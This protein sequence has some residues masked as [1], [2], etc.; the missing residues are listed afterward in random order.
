VQ[1]R[2]QSQARAQ[3][4]ALLRRA[5]LERLLRVVGLWVCPLPSEDPARVARQRALLLAPLPIRRSLAT[6]RFEPP[7]LAALRPFLRVQKPRHSQRA[8]APVPRGLMPSGW[9]EEVQALAD[10]ED[11]N[12]L[13]LRGYTGMTIRG[14]TSANDTTRKLE[15][16]APMPLAQRRQRGG[17]FHQNPD[18]QA[19]A[20]G[21]PSQYA[22]WS[23]AEA[24]P[25]Q[26]HGHPVLA[27]TLRRGG[28][29]RQ[30]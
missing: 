7:L 10:R 15:Q 27:P 19:I 5:L 4:L 18:P 29:T 16:V 12:E 20:R 2:E 17:F 24:P 6:A 9:A 21:K 28:H 3:A 22:S 1:A 23:H 13:A 8:R 11:S 25:P 14:E 26:A 30:A